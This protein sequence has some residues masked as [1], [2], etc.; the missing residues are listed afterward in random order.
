M[1]PIPVF[2]GTATSLVL[3]ARLSKQAAGAVMPQAIRELLA[4]AA[5]ENTFRS[6]IS[7][8]RHWT[9]W[10]AARYGIELGLPVP[11]TTVL[12]FVFDNVRRRSTGGEFGWE[13]PS[14]IDQALVAAGLKANVGPW[15]L[16]TSA[17]VRKMP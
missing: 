17:L 7:A 12:P 15:T 13:L 14:A 3:P 16:A 10:H 6:Y 1:L 2:T 5:A 8:L 11:E 9:G 4:E